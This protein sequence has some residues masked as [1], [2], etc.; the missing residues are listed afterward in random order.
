MSFEEKY[1]KMKEGGL[2]LANILK[3]LAK[4]IEPGKEYYYFEK[5]AE[6]L[7]LDSGMKPAFKNYQAPFAKRP[8]PYVLC[9]SVNE[10]IAHGYPEKNRYL[11]EGDVVSLDLG[12][13]NE[14]VY[15][16]AAITVGVG[17]I[18]KS[19]ENLINA[20]KQALE[21]SIKICKA[22]IRTGDIGWE[23]EKIITDSG[24]KVI[25]NL[26]GHDIGEYL[27]GEMQIFNFG[28]PG[29]GD[30]LEEGIFICLEPMASFDSEFGRQVDD[31]VFVTQYKDI[32][33]HFEATILIKKNK[34]EII[35]PI[36]D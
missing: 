3:T 12:L 18:E 31:Y 4:E 1:Q 13:I 30:I 6:E 14:G 15:L 11:K 2:V 33:T 22:G 16:D 9:F 7:I 10:V 25:K 26:C 36:L 8:Y 5:R 29:E 21:K 27:H 20:T 19:K 17:R 28:E 34:S 23:I 24:F 32:A 35:T